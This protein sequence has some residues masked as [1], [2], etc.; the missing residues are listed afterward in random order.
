[1]TTVE[2]DASKSLLTFYNYV[3][4]WQMALERKYG[5]HSKATTALVTAQHTL[6][7][8]NNLRKSTQYTEDLASSYRRGMLTLRS[9]QLPIFEFPDLAPSVNLWLPVQAYYAVHGLGIA[10]LIALGQSIPSN[11]KRF[12]AAFSASISR[13]L[14]YPFCSRCEGGP[15][16]G[17]FTFL[18]IGTS[19]AAIAS[20]S[21]LAHPEPDTV[22][23]LIGKSLSTTRSNL[24]D[25]TVPHGQIQRRPTA[26]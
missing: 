10:V 6:M 19:P 15:K 9:M 26:S 14:P 21:N 1:M 20:Q 12:C 24:L 25:E 17:G 8:F 3:S 16:P 18:S 7:A 22:D 11:H 5:T 23:A 4:A 2:N 13:L